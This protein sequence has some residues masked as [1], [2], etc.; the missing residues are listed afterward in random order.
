[1]ANRM[2]DSLIGRAQRQGRELSTEVLGL[3]WKSGEMYSRSTARDEMNRKSEIGR[4][5]V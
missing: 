2:V 1:M 4:A 5:H 3:K